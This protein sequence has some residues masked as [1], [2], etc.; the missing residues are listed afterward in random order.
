MTITQAQLNAEINTNLPTTGAGAVTAAIARQTLT[1]MTTAIFQS[2]NVLNVKSFGVV[3]NGITDDYLTIKA[4]DA[5][6][7]SAGGG[8]LFFPAGTYF[9]SLA[10]QPSSGVNYQ[11]AGRDVTI[12]KGQGVGPAPF[13]SSLVIAATYTGGNQ[14]NNLTG[15]AITYPID[16]PTEGTNT[17]KT[18][19]NSNAGNFSAGQFILISGDTH[20]TNFWY[21]DW[22]TTVVSANAGTGVITLAENLPFGGAIITTVQRLLAVPQNIKV[23]DMTILGTNDESLQVNAGQ[24][25]IFDNIAIRAGLGGVSGASPG[26]YAC[27][28][29]S[30]QDSVGYV[31]S[32]SL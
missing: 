14:Q 5:A 19:T 31:F 32:L 7:A 11:G 29:F 28:N 2:A 8:M 23:S 27:R 17:V 24:N 9:S 30:F 15:T 21:P 12:I 16:P 4:A 25:I 13:N 3:G 6:V 22:F 10:V 18:T 26:F 1:D 20:G